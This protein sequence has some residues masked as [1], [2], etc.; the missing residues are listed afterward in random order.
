MEA[1]TK[2]GDTIEIDVNT[3]RGIVSVWLTNEDQ[4]NEALE[5][6][7]K[8]QYPKWKEKKLQPV[9]YR[10]GKGDLRESVLEL[11][12]HNRMRIAQNEI[13]AEKAAKHSSVPEL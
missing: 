3:T 13:A 5:A 8:E 11:L 12:K 10:S 1:A 6:W 7:L 2:G 4:K 9:V